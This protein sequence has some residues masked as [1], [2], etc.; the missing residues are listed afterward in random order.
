[1]YTKYLLLIPLISFS[2]NVFADNPKGNAVCPGYDDWQRVHRGDPNPTIHKK[3]EKWFLSE[4]ARNEG[5][6]VLNHDKGSWWPSPTKGMAAL[7]SY[8]W[9]YGGVN[10]SDSDITNVTKGEPLIVMIEDYTYQKTTREYIVYCQYMWTNKNYAL[11]GF[12]AP[13]NSVSTA[14][15]GPT[16]PNNGGRLT[17]ITTVAVNVM[18]DLIPPTK[19]D[20]QGEFLADST[21]WLPNFL[22][23]VFHY[24]HTVF[25][26]YAIDYLTFKVTHFGTKPSTLLCSTINDRNLNQGKPT[27][28]D[29]CGWKWNPGV[30]NETK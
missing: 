19:K 17:G 21:N 11:E 1:M 28:P 9:K 8:E 30:W 13:K 3:G 15:I 14:S 24:L 18:H 22:Q 2:F 25:P 4:E 16:S 10:Y 23:S 7:T 20:G 5:W 29:V 27:G 26:F 6:R 12:T